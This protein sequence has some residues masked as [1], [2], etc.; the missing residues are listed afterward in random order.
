[1][2]S[3]QQLSGITISPLVLHNAIELHEDLEL[4][5]CDV[6]SS[7]D[8]VVDFFMRGTTGAPY[9]AMILVNAVGDYGARIRHDSLVEE[10]KY[11]LHLLACH[12]PKCSDA[13]VSKCK[14]EA[15]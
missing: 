8:F 4:V 2:R 12:L 11:W 9:T 3:Y 14:V 7:S 10:L 6:N 13:G 5:V 15:T 1:M